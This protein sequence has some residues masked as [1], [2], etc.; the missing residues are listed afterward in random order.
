MIESVEEWKQQEAQL[1]QIEKRLESISK[2]QDQ[3]DLA[4][5]HSLRESA[6]KIATDLKDF[7]NLE[8][9]NQA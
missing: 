7:I 8:F 4:E 9:A 1:L 5:V 3:I 6:R 2:S